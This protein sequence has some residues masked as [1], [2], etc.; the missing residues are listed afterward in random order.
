MLCV[1]VNLGKECWRQILL[2]FFFIPTLILDLMKGVG[3]EIFH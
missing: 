3:L 2:S 1:T